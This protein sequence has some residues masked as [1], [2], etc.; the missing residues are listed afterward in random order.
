MGR[1][2]FCILLKIDCFSVFENKRK[3]RMEENMRWC[4]LSKKNAKM[5]KLGEKK[6]K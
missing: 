3:I 4:G 6:V 5:M 2:L 1:K